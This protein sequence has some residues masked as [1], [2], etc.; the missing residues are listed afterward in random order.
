M[1][2]EPSRLIGRAEHPVELVR[3]HA[4]LAACHEARRQHP[5]R[6]RDMRAFHDG[7]DR[8]SERLTAVLAV[9]DARP[10]ACPLQ[11]PDSIAPNA[12]ARAHWTVRPEHAFQVLARG[13][14]IVEDRVAKIELVRCHDRNASSTMRRFYIMARTTSTG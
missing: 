6:Q 13:V 11:L 1:E 2:Q 10:G 4:L 14:I 8:N 5:F 7:A 3:R 9:V 12:A